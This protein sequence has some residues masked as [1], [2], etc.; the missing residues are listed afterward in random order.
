MVRV[1]NE[2][3]LRMKKLYWK[4]RKVKNNLVFHI[5]AFLHKRRDKLAVKKDDLSFERNV[6]NEVAK[7]FFK[8][9]FIIA[10]IL[11]VEQV[12]VSE[13]LLQ[14]LPNRV[15]NIQRYIVGLNA[16]IMEDSSILAGVLSAIIGVAGVFLWRICIFF[17]K[18]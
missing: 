16:N 14:I 8:N 15:Q 3:R 11:V 18:H 2:E 9:V 10:I 17:C 1:L 6:A 7:A 5:K 4:G 13:R 12:I